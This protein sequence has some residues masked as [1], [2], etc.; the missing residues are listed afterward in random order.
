[1]KSR[2]KRPLRRSAAKAK[3]GGWSWKRYW[4]W[5]ALPVAIVLN[6]IY[7]VVRIPSQATAPLQPYFYK[8]PRATWRAYGPLFEA[9]STALVPAPLLAALAQVE[10]SGNPIATTYWRWSW[11]WNPLRWYAPASSAAGLFQITD[12]TLAKARDLCIHDG[13]VVRRGPWWDWRGCWFNWLYNRLSAS[14][15]TELTSAFLT[16]SIEDSTGARGP[17]L[18]RFTRTRLA[19]AIH[20]CGPAFGRRLVEHRYQVARTE[21]CG[22]QNVA[23]YLRRVEHYV[24]VFE[25]IARSTN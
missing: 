6:T 13:K 1:M 20:L 18:S 17:L 14:H 22:D 21:R 5:L 12:G 16:Q 3:N 15:A 10:A 8:D 19:G 7:H 9:H 4:G 23:D 11:S 24:G 25:R 2:R